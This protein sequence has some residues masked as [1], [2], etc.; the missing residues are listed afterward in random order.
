MIIDNGLG[1]F[2]RKSELEFIGEE[3][4]YAFMTPKQLNNALTESINTFN[5]LYPPP[6]K[7][8]KFMR[9]VINVG[10]VAGTMAVAGGAVLA[11][12]G[13]SAPAATAAATSAATSAGASIPSMASVQAAAGYA[14]KAGL[15]YTAVTGDSPENL[16]KAADLISSDS[17]TDA[18][19]KVA[20]HE[21]E[22]RG[23]EIQAEDQASND[24]LRA[25]IEKEQAAMAE[26][27]RQAA[28]D[29]SKQIGQEPP[30]VK[31]PVDAMQVATLAIPVVLF[32][33]RS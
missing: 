26:K 17:A 22:K 31:K 33:L 15:V 2:Y 14:S 12:Y 19:E 23:A 18:M 24:A 1:Q 27:M 29:K 32:M 25:R 21:L 8:G 7:K 13:V 9:T 4:D 3:I 30:P 28:I 5:K 16:M 6:P 11:A 20:R 10:L